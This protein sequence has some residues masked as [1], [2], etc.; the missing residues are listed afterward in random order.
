MKEIKF[1]QP[2]LENHKFKGFHYWGIIKEGV[3]V[4]PLQDARFFNTLSYQYTGLKDSNGKEVYEGDIL[5]FV[6]LNNGCP[7]KERVFIEFDGLNF[8]VSTRQYLSVI[9]FC[10]G[11]LN[12]IDKRSG[13]KVIGNIYENPELLKIKKSSAIKVLEGEKD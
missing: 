12:S 1:R 7:H 3:F 9:M 4:A 5:E 6:Y 10:G 11:G 13:I 8:M 2:I